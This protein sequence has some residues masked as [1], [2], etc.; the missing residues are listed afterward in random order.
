M[1]I[2]HALFPALAVLCLATAAAT[3]APA[4]AA[5]GAAVNPKEFQRGLILTPDESNAMTIAHAINRLRAKSPMPLD[6]ADGWTDNRVKPENYD[7]TIVVGVTDKLT[8]KNEMLAK[9][10]SGNR[11]SDEEAWAL[12]TISTKPLIIAATGNRPRAVLYAVWR[13]ADMLAMGKDLSAINIVETPK[14]AK[15]YVVPSGTAIEG[16]SMNHPINRHNLYMSE[17]D[18]MPRYGINGVYFVLGQFRVG[19]GPGVVS[20]PL[21]MDKGGNITVNQNTY[22]QWRN[23]IETVK[24]YDMEAC[25][26]VEPYIPPGYDVKEVEKYYTGGT[27]MPDG[28]LEA[29]EKFFT[30]YVDKLMEIFPQMDGLVLHA[31]VEGANHSDASFQLVRTFLEGQDIPLSSKVMNVYLGV[32]EKA[33]QKYHIKGYFRTHSFGITSEGIL[34][35]RE[36]LFKYPDVTIIE[37]AYWPN[38]VWINGGGK[39]PIMAYLDDDLR[40][41]IDQHNKIGLFMLADAEYF[42]GGALPNA[43]DRCHIYA[44]QQLLQRNSDFV[45]LRTNL[46]DR[47]PFGTLWSLA[48]IQIEQAANQLWSPARSTEDVW[49]EWIERRWGAKAAPY[50]SKALANNYDIMFNGFTLDGMNAMFKSMIKAQQW[51]PDWLRG[52][53]KMMMFARPGTHLLAKRPD[54]ITS[55]DQFSVQLNNIAMPFKEFEAR[56]NKAAGEIDFSL[57]QIELAKPYL[58]KSD[59]VFLTET[60]NNAKI[61][62]GVIHDMAQAAYAANLVKDNFDKIP[63]PKAFFEKSISQLEARAA[64]KDVQWLSTVRGFLYGNVAE[65]LGKIVAAYRKYVSTGK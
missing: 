23:M 20:I 46:Q 41:R 62:L 3:T 16:R 8:E 28:F 55:T 15:R 59:Y 22:P 50:I 44:M 9:A 36:L 64:S 61:L 47:T 40:A 63:D 54:I 26:T 58:S 5:D 49:N 42:G 38:E 37:D 32:L 19:V 10:W 17:I 34:A 51:M 12:K 31:G 60:F 65:E 13:L 25:T 35:M 7:M 52:E 21:Q 27:K 30:R 4:V 48:G 56:Q 11:P 2:R 43:I 53:R 45:V 6:L 1:K 39:I 33:M 29:T 57:Q 14:L 24:S 18:E